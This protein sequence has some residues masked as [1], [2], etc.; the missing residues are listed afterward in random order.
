MRLIVGESAVVVVGWSCGGIS[1][2]VRLSRYAKTLLFANRDRRGLRSFCCSAG[3]CRGAS[4][5][6]PAQRAT[7]VD[8]MVE[9]R[10]EQFR[11]LPACG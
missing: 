9:P 2:A 6:L 7:K 4:W 8:P 11:I 10:Y 3:E 5:L 1:M